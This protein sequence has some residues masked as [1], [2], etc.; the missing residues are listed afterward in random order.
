[1][2]GEHGCGRPRVAVSRCLLGEP[3]RHNGNHSRARYLTDELAPFVDWVPICPEME[4]GLG[5]PRESLRLVRSPGGPRP[6]GRGSGLEPP[7][8]KTAPAGGASAELDVAGSR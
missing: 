5:T 7:P 3:V 6:V 8:R 2:A 1:M 4:I